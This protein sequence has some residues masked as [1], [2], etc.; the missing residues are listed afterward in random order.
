MVSKVIREMAPIIDP[1]EDYLT[2]LAAE[3]QIA[4]TEMKRKKELEESHANLKGMTSLYVD[5]LL[6]ADSSLSFALTARNPYRY[7]RMKPFQRPLRQPAFLPLDRHL[8]LQQKLMLPRST[9]SIPPV[10]PL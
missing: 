8:F 1:E 9:N 3:E 5:Y 2:I 10:F 7:N 4:T 6:F